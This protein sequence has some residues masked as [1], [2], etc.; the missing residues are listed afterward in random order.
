MIQINEKS[1]ENIV[2]FPKNQ[3][4]TG[5]LVLK[6]HSEITQKTYSFNVVDEGSSKRYYKFTLD[7]SEVDNGEYDYSI[8]DLETG[9]IRIG[10][11]ESSTPELVEYVDEYNI[12]QYGEDRSSYYR[13][14]NKEVTYTENGENLVTADPEYYGLK[15][16]V[17]NVELPVDEY[18]AEGYTSGIT[19]G[20]VSGKTDGYASGYTE[21]YSSGNTDGYDSGYTVGYESGHTDG[22]AEQK[23][24]LIGLDINSNG[25][26]SRPDGW[27]AVTV[28]VP[29][30]STIN[31]QNKTVNIVNNGTTSVTFDSGY[32]GLGTVG[33]N[34]AVPT[35]HSDAELIQVYESGFTAGYASGNAVGYANGKTEGY[36][37]GITYQ[38][39]L[40][41]S[42][43][44]T[45]NGT[46][47]SENGFSSVMVSV[48]GS[49]PSYDEMYFTLEFI[50]GGTLAFNSHS[51]I[52]RTIDYSLNNGEWT[53]VTF[54]G[55]GI[56]ELNVSVGDKVR[57]RGNH[58][59]DGYATGTTSYCSI[60]CYNNAKYNAYG[61]FMSML[62]GDNFVGQ[63]TLELHSNYPLYKF[64]SG[65]VDAEN[66][67]LP[68]TALTQSCYAY[69]FHSCGTLIKAPTLPAA[70]LVSQCYALM[71]NMCYNL[72]YIKCLA[73]D[74]SAGYCTYNWVQNVPSSG[75]V[76]VK[77]SGTSWTTGDSGIP[78]G[79]TVIEE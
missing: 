51:N 71:F 12:V 39:S 53:T 37:S 70:T 74:I 60:V 11:I 32:T 54:S 40:L 6:L 55:V 48:S 38:K 26:Y 13:L 15:N 41:V 8:N 49:S 1:S 79:W 50:S 58:S 47:T 45:E 63:E 31:N 76:F 35:G 30:G 25:T 18:Y 62:Y 69:M 3:N 77:K 20:Y 5:N 73:T 59:S 78:T 4:L 75:G 24:K 57:L 66:M 14:Q 61:N 36:T 23:A 46:Y 34:V 27:S 16:V 43:A 65:C 2:N 10:M 68:A 7:F 9:L 52:N 29:T 72:Q 64:I 44:V 17:V 33:I 21:G 67:V 22:V 42:T 28:N 19:D 56:T